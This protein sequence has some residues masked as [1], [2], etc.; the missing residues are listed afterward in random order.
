MLNAAFLN[1]L[2]EGDTAY[3]ATVF[4][5]IARELPVYW[6]EMKTAH[7]AGSVKELK[8]AAHKCKTLFAYAGYTQLQTLLQQ[9]EDGC[10]GAKDTGALKT[11]MEYLENLLPGAERI[12]AGEIK[13]LHSFY[14]R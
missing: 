9:I 1:E 10:A 7:A 2:F 6:E 12:I 3:A 5:G 14:E 13:R 11:E 4:E 8:A